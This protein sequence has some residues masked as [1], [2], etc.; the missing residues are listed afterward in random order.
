MDCAFGSGSGVL[1]V[2][3]LNIASAA[4]RVSFGRRAIGS[5]PPT[6]PWNAPYRLAPPHVGRYVSSK[7][8]LESSSQNIIGRVISEAR[9]RH[10]ACTHLRRADALCA[11]RRCAENSSEMRKLQR[12]GRLHMRLGE[13]WRYRAEDWRGWRWVSRTGHRQVNDGFVQCM[14]RLGRG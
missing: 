10:Q 5:D 1:A 12:Q 13:W 4:S 7:Y 6:L 2:A 14:R 9:Q 11:K 3:F 8:Y